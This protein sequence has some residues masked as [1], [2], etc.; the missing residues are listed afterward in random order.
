VLAC[1]YALSL[2]K[3]FSFTAQERCAAKALEDMRGEGSIGL[4]L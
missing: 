1:N 2:D 3:P 4:L